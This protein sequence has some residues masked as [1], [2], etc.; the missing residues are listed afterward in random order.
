MDITYSPLSTP[1]FFVGINSSIGSCTS[2]TCTPSIFP[3]CPLTSAYI[4]HS[5]SSSTATNPYQSSIFRPNASYVQGPNS[6]SP[7]SARLPYLTRL[8]SLSTYN[9]PSAGGSKDVDVTSAGVSLFMK[10]RMYPPKG[11]PA[12]GDE[13]VLR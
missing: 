4:A 1:Y 8:V 7:A 12:V 11:W 10:S 9:Q 13:V 5:P 6:P 2:L 3:S